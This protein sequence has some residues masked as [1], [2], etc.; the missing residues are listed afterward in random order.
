MREDEERLPPITED[1]SAS[2]L[3][4]LASAGGSGGVPPSREPSAHPIETVTRWGRG[5]VGGWGG[6]RRPSA[7][8]RCLAA[9]GAAPR[10]TL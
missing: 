5:R 3:Q 1:A 4:A 9:V 8:A 10:L 2:D 6:E 7:S